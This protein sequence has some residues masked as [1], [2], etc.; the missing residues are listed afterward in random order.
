MLTRCLPVVMRQQWALY[1]DKNKQGNIS[2]TLI[3]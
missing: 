1:L 3:Y 2:Y